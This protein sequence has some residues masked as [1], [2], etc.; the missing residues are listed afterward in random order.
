V[1]EYH[2]LVGTGL[3]NLGHPLHA[4]REAIRDLLRCA[5]ETMGGG[6]VDYGQG[7]YKYRNGKSRLE[8]SLRF[9][10]ITDHPDAVRAFAQAAKRVLNQ[11]SVLVVSEPVREEIV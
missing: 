2:V 9:T 11:E 5:A 3:D 4:P 1:R 10:L 7:S 6:T 8:A